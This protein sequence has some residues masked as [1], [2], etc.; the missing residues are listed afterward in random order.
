MTDS[1]SK[2]AANHAGFFRARLEQ[3]VDIAWLGGLRVLFGL[4]MCVS[5]LRYIVYGWIEPFFVRPS[6]HFKYFGFEWLEP[7]PGPLMHGLFCALALLGFLIALGV[8]F[9]ISA[10]LFA[11]GFAYLQLVDVTTYL[12]HY[13]LAALLAFLLALSPADRFFS[14]RTHR[15][16]ED[17]LQTLPAIWLWL[18]R[19]QVGVVYTFAGVAKAHADWLVY[20]QPLRIW[21]GSHTDMPVVGP[22]FTL[23]GIPLFMSWAGFVFDTSII[24]FLMLPRARPYAYALVIFFHAFNRTLFPIGMF[25][26]IMVMAALV[27]F[28]PSWPR[29]PLGWL[30]ERFGL[31]K[32]PFALEHVAVVARPLPRIA[33]WAFTLYCLVQLAF[34]LRFLAYGGNVRWHEQGMRFSW[35]VMVREKNGSVTFEVR[36]KKTGRV[37]FVSP[38]SY[39]TRLQEREMSGQPDLILQLA[40]H[41]RD[42]FA[43]RGLGE[44]SVMADALVSLNGRAMQRLLD[45]SVDLAATRDSLRRAAW[46]LPAP[47]SPPPLVRPI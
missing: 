19:I 10:W 45:P 27:F 22:L 4:S 1:A 32:M 3:P 31:Q 26:A 2:P 7:L 15:M 44:V 16:P 18:F 41:I 47:E 30:R 23:D 46:I 28:S 43:R 33:I 5:M 12:N 29:R 37:W 25:S 17:R 20:A 42:D 39:L 36:Q 38:H 24:W 35:R 14:L 13:Y 6:F 40:H 11:L 8:C 9:R 21:L 34:P